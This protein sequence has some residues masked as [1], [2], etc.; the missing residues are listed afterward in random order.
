MEKAKK[1]IDKLTQAEKKSLLAILEKLAK[2]NDQS[3]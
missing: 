3:R 1:R 2:E